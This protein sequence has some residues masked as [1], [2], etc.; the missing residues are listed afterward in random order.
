MII[1]LKA[2]SMR[3]IYL[4]RSMNTDI[5]VVSEFLEMINIHT[6]GI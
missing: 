6:P 3:V 1:V 4:W 5:T 2:N